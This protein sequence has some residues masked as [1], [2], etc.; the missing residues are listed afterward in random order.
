MFTENDPVSQRINT[1]NVVRVQRKQAAFKT[2]LCREFL[3]GHCSYG[4]NCT[5]AHGVQELRDPNERQQKHPKYKSMPCNKFSES[6]WC[7]YG[8]RCQ[9]EH[10]L[11]K[12]MPK[13]KY[14]ALLAAGRITPALGFEIVDIHEDE[15]ATEAERLH[16][17]RASSNGSASDTSEK[18]Q[19]STWPSN[20]E[21]GHK[22]SKLDDFSDCGSGSSG[23]NPF[24]FR[25]SV[26]P[27]IS[28][29]WMEDRLTEDWLKAWKPFEPTPLEMSLE[30]PQT[31][32]SRMITEDQERLKALYKMDPRPKI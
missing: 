1:Y 28:C 27:D 20:N 23:F 25:A 6:G 10:K 22:E 31:S 11:Y 24:R 14:D 17:M 32:L 18:S 9:F 15:V 21:G 4:Q 7:R 2:S 16:R 19:Q 30:P 5:Y 26:V 29:S 3:H 12:G 8:T 13:M